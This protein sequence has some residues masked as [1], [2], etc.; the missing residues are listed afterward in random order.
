M[1]SDKLTDAIARIG[2]ATIRGTQNYSMHVVMPEERGQLS[3]LVPGHG[4]GHHHL[5]VLDLDAHPECGTADQHCQP[6][7]RNQQSLRRYGSAACR[8][9]PCTA[10]HRNL[11]PFIAS[12]TA[13]PAAAS[14]DVAQSSSRRPAPRNRTLAEGVKR[15]SVISSGVKAT[16]F[17]AQTCPTTSGP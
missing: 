14:V 17:G 13:I 10:S 5:I 6:T 16:I 1:R 4:A 8:F 7:G 9:L 3:T 12:A 2:V 11:V 15:R